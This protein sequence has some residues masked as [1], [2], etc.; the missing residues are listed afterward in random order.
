M[1]SVQV[2]AWQMEL[3]QTPLAGSAQSAPD[4]QPLPVAH[5]VAQ[6]PPQ[7]TSVSLPFLTVSVQLAFWQ[8]LEVHT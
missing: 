6:V 5:F 8:T 1:L 2:A 3:V 7:S 4:A